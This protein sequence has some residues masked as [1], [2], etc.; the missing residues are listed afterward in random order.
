MEHFHKF[1]IIAS[2]ILCVKTKGYF[3]KKYIVRVVISHRNRPSERYIP[4]LSFYNW[5]AIW[6][7]IKKSSFWVP[8][9]GIDLF[10]SKIL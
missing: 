6:W 1:I 5:I 8:L 3:F 7:V 2:R 4:I 10:I 9:K